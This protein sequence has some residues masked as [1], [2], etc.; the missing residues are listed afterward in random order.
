M[1]RREPATGLLATTRPEGP[2]CDKRTPFLQR[3][4]QVAALI[5][6]GRSNKEISTALRIPEP[7]VKKHVG[8]ILQKLGWRTCFL[9]A[10]R[11]V[12]PEGT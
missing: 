7:T 6:E 12:S 1:V 11:E 4:L 10:H 3:E 2:R 5:A 9:L 8:H